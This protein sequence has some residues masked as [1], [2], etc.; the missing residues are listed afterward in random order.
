MFNA[1]ALG[2]NKIEI[3]FTIEKKTIVTALNSKTIQ[4]F[5][6]LEQSEYRKSCSIFSQSEIN[7]QCET[8]NF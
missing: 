4:S 7:K 6:T 3:P 8:G 2:H 5:W 1:K